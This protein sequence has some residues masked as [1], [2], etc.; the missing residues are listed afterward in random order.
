MRD[1][2][3][4][5]NPRVQAQLDRLGR[6]SL[7]QGRLGLEVI[8]ALLARLGDPHKALPPVFHVA[9]TNGKGST[10][11][12]LRAMLEA[13]GLTVHAATKPH[14]V[15]YNERIRV[16]GELVSDDLLADLLQEVLD[17]GEDLSPSFFE[18][19]TAATFLAFHRIPADACVIEVGLGGRFDAT[20]VLDS[21]AACGIA[22]LGIDHKEFLLVP[23]EGVPQEPL[24]RIAFEKAGIARPG[25]PLVTQAYAPDVT[26]TVIDHAM[27]VGAKT[28]IRGL[29]WDAAIGAEIAYR[30]RLGELTLPLPAL[31]GTHQADNAALAVAM[32]RHQSQVAVSPEAMADGIRAARWPARLQLLGD[33]PLTAL[34]PGRKVWLDGGHNADAGLA[35]GRHFAG[36]P[37]LHLITG[38]L[39]NKD[40]AAIVAPLK[41]KLLSLSVVPAPGHEAH[42]PED[43]AVHADRPVRPFGDVGAALRALPPEGDVLIAGSLYLAGEVLRLNREF[44]D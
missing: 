11:A 3:I 23:E 27:T 25:V 33:G 43:I 40:P 16:A 8:H 15:R 13:E 26:K 37:P 14:L 20:N 4:S 38:M 42:R 6:L 21:Q 24:C 10:C 36:S 35:I 9:G 2:A 28:A 7:P 12:Y 19:T 41:G 18:V 32:L 34:V 31:A 29:D 44:P 39:A 22:T 17:R 1:F 5:D 30:D